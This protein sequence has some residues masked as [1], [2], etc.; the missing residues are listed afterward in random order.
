MIDKNIKLSTHAAFA[1]LLISTSAH[2]APGYQTTTL[3]VK[4]R[5]QSL[6]LHIW[7]PPQGDG[8]KTWLGKNIVF[9]GV[10]VQKA[11]APKKAAHPLIL[12]SHGSGGNAVNLGWIAARL[13]DEGAIVV[14]TNHPG[15]TSRDSHPR[16]TI[17]IWQRTADFSAILDY[18]QKARP[19]GLSVDGAKIGAVGFSLGGY[20]VL[21]LAGG[22]VSKQ[23]FINYC[24]QY[25][26][27]SDCI[28]IK[29]GVDLNDIDA[30]KFE[31]SN[32]DPRIAVVVAV[33]PALAQ[34]Y[35]PESLQ[36]IKRPVLL[37]NQGAAD[38]VP[39]GINVRKIKQELPR[40]SYSTIKGATHFSF[41]GECTWLGARIIESEG[42][43]PICSEVS[44]RSRADIH[45]EIGDLIVEYMKKQL[46]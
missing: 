21:G 37:I 41:L 6:P 19:F 10:E 43:E 27:L 28:W 2:A 20:T 34:A 42:E 12:L 45:K 29:N 3:D 1:I 13:A 38:K 7:Y 15:T 24:T 16:E 30:K 25:S 26:K 36:Q 32:A 35:Q 11:A 39:A 23:K 46:F 22:R 31:Q 44:D 4:H 14:S 5:E 9:K 40:A 18:M 17:K 8:A 33:D